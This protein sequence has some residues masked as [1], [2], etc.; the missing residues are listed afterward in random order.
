[1]LVGGPLGFND[2]LS[3]CSEFKATGGPVRHSCRPVNAGLTDETKSICFRSARPFGSPARSRKAGGAWTRKKHRIL[4]ADAATVATAS[5][6]RSG[7]WVA[8]SN[9]LVN[10]PSMSSEHDDHDFDTE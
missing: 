10:N 9:M 8:A 5:H 7:S 3:T 1:M 4:F 6:A 2:Q